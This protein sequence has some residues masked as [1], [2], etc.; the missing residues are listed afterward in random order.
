MK[1]KTIRDKLKDNFIGLLLIMALA[2]LPLRVSDFV[3]DTL[4]RTFIFIVVAITLDFFSG[5]TGYLN[6][7]HSFIFGLSAY[8]VGILYVYLKIPTEIA[9]LGAGLIGTFGSLLLLLPSLRV[10]GVYFAILSLLYP[11]I[12][13]GIV[14]TQPF[15][16]Y[17]GGE[18][19]LRFKQLFID[20]ARQLPPGQRLVFLHY[21]YY[22]LAFILMITS[23]IILY[24]LAYNEFGFKLR[25][26]GQDE[27]L[28]EATGVDTVVTKIKGFLIS[29][30]FVSFAGAL[31]AG[32]RPPVTIDFVSTGSIL[33]PALT[34]MI[35][36]GAGTIVGPAIASFVLT[37][38]YQYLWGVVG[39]WRTV[40]YMIILLAF[41]LIRPQGVVFDTYLRF[42]KL[43]KGVIS[44]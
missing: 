9:I 5:T 7:G 40:V 22:Y 34:A 19:G 31:Y 20:I 11:I 16:F 26:I 3:L 15:S 33:L 10:R 36:G 13:M 1:R 44:K 39:L 6:L 42:K 23:Y 29:S 4:V 43:I 8:M 38:L 41:V 17:L 18:G 28:A 21:S 30:V 2:V 14:T 12:F 24:K 35:V 25:S 32:M 37:I 27:D